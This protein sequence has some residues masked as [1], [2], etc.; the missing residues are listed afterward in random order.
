MPDP[1]TPCSKV[2]PAQA[3][4]LYIPADRP[5][6]E[7]THHLPESLA[8]TEVEKTRY[9]EKSIVINQS[10]HWLCDPEKSFNIPVNSI[11]IYEN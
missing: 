3:V 7:L 6:Y 2:S 5:S 9:T 1:Q 8:S 11:F 10:T 4:H